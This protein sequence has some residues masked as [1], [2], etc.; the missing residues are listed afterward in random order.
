MA[1]KPIWFFMEAE[2]E[3]AMTRAI[4]YL[5]DYVFCSTLRAW[6]TE[7]RPYSKRFNT[8]AILRIA[9]SSWFSFAGLMAW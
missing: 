3:A 1:W 7:S 2:V 9:E 4:I 6:K 5:T 8:L